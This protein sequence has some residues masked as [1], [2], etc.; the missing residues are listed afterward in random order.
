MKNKGEVYIPLSQD[1]LKYK[2]N[3]LNGVFYI[4]LARKMYPVLLVG[5]LTI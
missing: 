5:R 2:S 4:H 1:I 3:G